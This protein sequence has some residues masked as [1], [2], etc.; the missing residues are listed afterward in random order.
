[1]N[2]GYLFVVGI[3]IGII[4]I[5]AV[6]SVKNKKKQSKVVRISGKRIMDWREKTVNWK[7]YSR[8]LYRCF[9]R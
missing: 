5:F 2:K 3:I 8:K 7:T 6:I 9:R 4:I 1:M